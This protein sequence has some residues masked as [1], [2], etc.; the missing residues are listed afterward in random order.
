M[1]AVLL[2]EMGAL[3]EV[4]GT[5]TREAE[6]SAMMVVTDPSLNSGMSFIQVCYSH[7]LLILSRQFETSTEAGECLC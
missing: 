7:H 5:A 1:S 6:N 2:E 3:V 4:R